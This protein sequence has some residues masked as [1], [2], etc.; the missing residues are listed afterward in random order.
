MDEIPLQLRLRDSVSQRL[1]DTG[2]VDIWVAD[3]ITVKARRIGDVVHVKGESW[4]YFPVHSDWTDTTVLPSDMR[5]ASTVHFA[6]MRI[7]TEDG[8][9]LSGRVNNDGHVWLI[10]PNVGECSYWGFSA[11]FPVG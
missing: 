8:N 10:A 7:A 5:P 9:A 2:W 6:G 3:G 11:T 1:D 4:G